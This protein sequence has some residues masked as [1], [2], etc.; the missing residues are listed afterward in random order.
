MKKYLISLPALFLVASLYGQKPAEAP[1]S[2]KMAQT[3]FA[4]VKAD[5]KLPSEKIIIIKEGICATQDCEEIFSGLPVEIYA[6]EDL[7]M[8]G[9]D[10]YYRLDTIRTLKEGSQ[11]QLAFV[12]LIQHG[13]AKIPSTITGSF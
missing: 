1:L 9:L 5:E 3:Y 7:F 8:R 4:A 10:N 12:Y 11:W 6:R 2:K 13:K